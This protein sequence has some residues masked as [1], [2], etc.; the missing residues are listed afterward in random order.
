MLLIS[1][2]LKYKTHQEATA[3]LSQLQ[4]TRYPDHNKQT[5][6]VNLLPPQEVDNVKSE[7]APKR[8]MTRDQRNAALINRTLMLSGGTSGNR[9]LSSSD[10]G[11]RTS[12]T[13]AAT[14]IHPF[15]TADVESQRRSSNQ[16]GF[17]FLN[18]AVS[19]SASAAGRI[20]VDPTYKI[21]TLPKDIPLEQYFKKTQ[22]LPHIYWKPLTD[23]EVAR[24][25]TIK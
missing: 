17:S 6:L 2:L 8:S 4:G 19:E 25:K 7:N 12:D 3:A 5:L 1:L 16:G 13:A 22:T 23:E 15:S 21:P 10:S 9:T 18:R 11:P 24:K 14:A 20:D